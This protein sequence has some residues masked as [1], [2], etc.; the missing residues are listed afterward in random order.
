MLYKLRRNY[1]NNSNN[2]NEKETQTG[3]N[4]YMN[5]NSK[6]I[7]TQKISCTPNICSYMVALKEEFHY[8]EEALWP[9][10]IGME[11]KKSW[12]LT[13]GCHAA[14]QA[15][16]EQQNKRL[17][18][19]EQNLKKESNGT[20][21]LIV[22][23]KVTIRRCP[24]TTSVEEKGKPKQNWAEVLLLTDLVPYHQ[25]KQAHYNYSG[26]DC[27]RCMCSPPTWCLT[28]RTNRLTTV[29]VG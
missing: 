21:P 25:D 9:L 16:G 17:V 29:T 12:R 7:S 8:S 24:W 2:D 6:N 23:T 5:T 11:W 28:T 22:G 13:S 26:L 20:C 19:S 27:C 18:G 10:L 3:L 15:K 1:D 14:S 4:A